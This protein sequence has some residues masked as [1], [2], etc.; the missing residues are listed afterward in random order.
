MA[1]NGFRRL[2]TVAGCAVLLGGCGPDF[3]TVP[4]AGR[5]TFRGA[6]PPARGY[7]YFV[8]VADGAPVP[9]GTEPRSG[10]AMWSE[11]GS[12]QA[13]TFRAAD[14][15]RPGTYEVRIECMIADT[16]RPVPE[17]QEPTAR[18]AVPAGSQPPPLVVPAAGPRPVRYDL[19]LP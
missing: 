6:E 10:S 1:R 8:P 11:D 15:L 17:G 12:F 3:G 7:L 2:G 14:G 5:V 9:H 19:N 16:G 13:G 4:V 18:S